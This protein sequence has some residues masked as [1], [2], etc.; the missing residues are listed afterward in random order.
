MTA[1]GR[2]T[3][4]SNP[5]QDHLDN[6]VNKTWNYAKRCESW[7]DH[8]ENAV[9]GLAGEAGELA[10]Q[11]KKMFYHTEVDHSFHLNKI[12]HE[13]GDICFYLAKVIELHGLT[14]EEVLEANRQKLASRHPELGEVTER[15]GKGHIE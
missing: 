4:M 6:V 15:F 8:V 9:L 5:L 14:L 12:K 1:F 11:H 10:D 7:K 2:R 13:L 3:R